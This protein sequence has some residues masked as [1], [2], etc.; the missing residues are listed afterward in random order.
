MDKRGKALIVIAGILI[1]VVLI[2]VPLV[3]SADS[4]NIKIYDENSKTVTIKNG[5]NVEIASIQLNTPLMNYVPR[6]YQ[7]VAEFTINSKEAYSN[8]FNDMKFYDL[9]NNNQIISRQFD[10]KVR[11]YETIIVDDY[12]YRCETKETLGNGTIIQDCQNV[13]V[14]S[15]S[16]QKEVWTQ[17][18]GTDFN[19]GE[20]LT[21]GIFTDVQKGDNVEWIATLYGVSI[22]EWAGWTESLNSGLQV[23][24]K[25]DEANG[26]IVDS[27]GN[28]N[29]TV[30]SGD[31]IYNATGRV[32]GAI[33][34]DG[35]GNDTFIDNVADVSVFSFNS[36]EDLTYNFWMKAPVQPTA[37]H[38]L[39]NLD[40]GTPTSVLHWANYDTHVP[41]TD[42]SMYGGGVGLVVQG[43]GNDNWNMITRIRNNSG[44]DFYVYVNGVYNISDLGNSAAAGTA[45]VA[46]WGDY[47]GSDQQLT[48]KVDEF[49]FW[50]RSL[51]GSEILQLYNNGSG[52]SYGVYSPNY[53]ITFNLTDSNTGV[54]IDTSGPQSHFDISCSNNFATTDVDNPYNATNFG[55][56]IVEC[57]F[58]NLK[59]T[60]LFPYFDKTQNITADSNKTVNIPMSKSG[61]LTPEEH[62]WLE[63]IHNCVIN[64]IGCY[65]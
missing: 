51:S 27:I 25:F 6:G 56:G 53:T 7:K 65:S 52:I 58:S 40:L 50:K 34:F 20:V 2:V 49:G 17:L 32:G 44:Q 60:N 5:S 22:N 9:K 48:Y 31:P 33:Q 46:V 15:H 29:L 45:T 42:L 36:T 54:Q 11:S 35:S 12:E 43:V 63:A 62:D 8:V 16:E 21:I 3:F 38:Y 23:Y 37:S 19:E 14:S 41:R 39:F 61:G 55:N 13:K 57:T 4:E 18:E 24:W 28:V 64:G 26:T 30:W 10:Y 47:G 1:S 59:D